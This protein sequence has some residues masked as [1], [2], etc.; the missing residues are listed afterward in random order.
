MLNPP[1]FEWTGDFGREHSY[2][3][4]VPKTTFISLTSTGGNI[5]RI[6]WMNTI[7][8]KGFECIWGAWWFKQTGN[9][10]WDQ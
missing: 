9:Q 2:T 3:R 4:L 8:R 10:G 6:H 7:Q 5:G 1:L